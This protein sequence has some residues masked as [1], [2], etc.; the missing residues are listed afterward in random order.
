MKIS[1]LLERLQDWCWLSARN[2]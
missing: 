2:F 1:Q